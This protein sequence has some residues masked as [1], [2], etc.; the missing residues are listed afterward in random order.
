[1]TWREDEYPW[2]NKD[3][4]NSIDIDSKKGD[5]YKLAVVA[6]TP[7]LQTRIRTLLAEYKHIFS[8]ELRP[9]PAKLN[10]MTIGIDRDKWQCNKNSLP[11]RPQSRAKHEEIQR[12]MQ[13]MLDNK[14][15][16]I[17]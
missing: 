7:A 12:Q 14:V 13:K 1:M 2:L 4:D 17:S 8:E 6:G 16:K 11:P 5:S 10:P 3:T 15:I 9:E